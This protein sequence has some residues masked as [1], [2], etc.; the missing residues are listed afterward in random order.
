M[1][2]DALSW[3]WVF[4]VNVPLAAVGVAGAAFILAASARRRRVPLDLTGAGL[5]T[6]GLVA[7]VYGLLASDSHGWGSVQ[8]AGPLAAAVV[9][10]VIFVVHQARWTAT[11]LVPLSIFRSRSLSAANSVIFG[12]G[13]GFFASFVLL[14]VYLQDALGYSPLKAGLAFLPAAAALFTGAQ[15][16]GHLTHR[17]GIRAIAAVGGLGAIAGCVRTAIC[18]PRARAYR[19][20]QV[21][22]LEASSTRPAECCC[23]M[24]RSPFPDEPRDSR[25]RRAAPADKRALA[26]GLGQRSG[27]QRFRPD[28]CA[29]RAAFAP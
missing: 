29:V 21:R 19:V 18:P 25:G 8:V 4:L 9:L 13:L 12:L 16:A 5:A 11:P 14:S 22:A 26:D 10:G 2:T 28:M 17:Y 20:D 6:G 24:A 23:P 27:S 7:L 15:V 1:L 3:R